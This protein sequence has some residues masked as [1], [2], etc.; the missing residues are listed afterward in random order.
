MDPTRNKGTFF[1]IS[2]PIAYLVLVPL[3]G[4]CIKVSVAN[5]EGGRTHSPMRNPREL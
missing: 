4:S 1:T 2:L 3:P 5:A